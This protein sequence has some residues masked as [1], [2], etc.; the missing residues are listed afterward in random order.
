[1]R[2]SAVG[3][4][5]LPVRLGTLLLTAGVAFVAW[6]GPAPATVAQSAQVEQHVQNVRTVYDMLLDTS[7][8]SPAPSALI[9][10]AEQPLLKQKNASGSRVAAA[11]P[12]DRVAAFDAF[13]QLFR[14]VTAGLP[15]AEIKRLA[16]QA[17]DAMARSL[18]D[19]HT[20]FAAPP[21]ASAP[22]S[23]G[24]LTATYGS[25]VFVRELAPNGPAELAGVRPGDTIISINGVDVGDDPAT[26]IAPLSGSVAAIDLRVNRPNVGALDFTISP[27]TVSYPRW[28]STVLPNGVGYMRLRGFLDAFRTEPNGLTVAQELDRTLADFDAQGV[29]YWVLDLRNNGGGS[30][31]TSQALLGRFLPPGTLVDRE[32][33]DRGRQAQDTVDGHYAL[34]QQPMALLVNSR[35]FSAAEI[36]SSSLSESGRALLVGQRTGGALANAVIWPAPEGARLE[37][38]FARVLSGIQNA[39]IDRV[40]V[41]VDIEVPDR[42]PEDYAAGRDPQLDAAIGALESGVAPPPPSGVSPQ[43]G[44]DQVLLQVLLDPLIDATEQP[45]APGN[46]LGDQIG[47]HTIT[48]TDDLN[49][50]STATAGTSGTGGA[51][52]A[53]AFERT[54]TQR[55]WLGGQVEVFRSLSGGSD[56]WAQW[57]V[58]ATPD[59]ARQAVA[60][61]DFPDQWAPSAIAVSLGDDGRAAVYDGAWGERGTIVVRWRRGSL[62]FTAEV[63]STPAAASPELAQRFAR[64]VD[65]GWAAA[66]ARPPYT[67]V[68]AP[69]VRALL[70]LRTVSAG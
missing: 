54:A 1:M 6:A 44:A 69:L 18:D 63:Q 66:Q 16:F 70:T 7:V 24:I 60:A 47:K 64:Q 51:R 59:G 48:D 31:L 14:Q 34:H 21:A 53:A 67:L 33:D 38:A 50:W 62:V 36:T 19:D 30:G 58:Y 55:G 43:P 56:L 3:H 32:S 26:A 22:V 20:N 11:V 41:P 29:Q 68:I 8:E 65:A 40:G 2:N 45:T 49:D 9:A 25:S 28:T 42:T 12:A 17:D 46:Q 39:V 57:D 15:D 27:G 13:A 35:S 4:M 61:N 52:D 37:I 10:A 5:K 23:A